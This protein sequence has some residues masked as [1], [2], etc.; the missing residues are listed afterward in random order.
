MARLCLLQHDERAPQLQLDWRPSG[1]SRGSCS[2]KELEDVR[3]SS[4]VVHGSSRSYGFR[5][6]LER[7]AQ[8]CSIVRL[9]STFEQK[10]KIQLAKRRAGRAFSQPPLW[11]N[12]VASCCSFVA[13]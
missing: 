6:D 5:L 2:T 13:G 4:S 8:G 9:T 7:S 10:D 11:R 3:R 12:L 1:L